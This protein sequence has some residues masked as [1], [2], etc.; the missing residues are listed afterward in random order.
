M[1]LIYTFTGGSMRKGTLFGVASALLSCPWLLSAQEP[2]DAGTS[3]A[4][5]PGSGSAYSS[6]SPLESEQLS[7]PSVS[8][9]FYEIAYELAKPKEVRGPELEQA[10]TFL[11]AAMKLDKNAKGIRPLLIEFA[12]RERTPDRSGLVYEMLVEYVDEFA[13]LEV[14]RKAVGY[15][16]DRAN[17]REER[18]RLL[19]RMLGTLGNK[20]NILGSELATLLGVLKAEKADSEA[21]AHY[22]MQAYRSHRYNAVAFAKLAEVAPEQISPAVYLERLRLALRENPSDID[23]AV[24]FAEY[25]E[26]LQ[27]YETAA[28]AYEYCADLF[29][30]LY[31]SEALPARIY[32]P[33]AISSYNTR[34]DQSQCAQ[35]AERI[36]A[37]GEFDLRLEAIAAKA[38]IKLGDNESAARTFQAAEEKA[39]KL[40][41]QQEGAAGAV[42]AGTVESANSQQVTPEQLAWFYCLAL[43]M[44]D[45]ALSWA[46]QVYAADSNSPVTAALL[47]CALVMNEQIEWAKPLIDNYDRNQIADLALAQIQLA[48]GQASLAIE[49]LISAIARDPGSFAA[50]RSKE[51]LAGQ[52]REY[53][54]PVAPD[55]VLASL[56]ST[57]GQTLVPVFTRP[58]Q[59]L[60]AQ[61]DIRGNTIPYGGELSGMAV[62][63]NSSSE[64]LVISDDGLFKGNIR[65]DADISG[66][67]TKHI[68]NLV[69]TKIQA[70][71][72]VEPGRSI[73]I[74]LRLM[75]G[76]LRQTLLTYPQASL[77]IEC[78]LY[79]DPVLTS[80]GTV[81]NRL[82]Q[83]RP[84]KVRVDRPGVELTTK[85]LRDQFN[86]ISTDRIDQKIK[87]AQ[88]FT[89]L[90]AEQ[91]AMANRKPLYRFMYAD[92][93]APL[94][95]S[96]LVHESGLLRHPGQTEW[97]VK[98]HTMAEMLPLSLD[99]ELTSAAADNL[100]HPKWPV[101]MMA[102]YLLANQQ[103][104]GFGKV[105]D[106]AK[107][108]PSQSVCDMATALSRASSELQGRL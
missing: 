36:R 106:W 8:R 75:T 100:H 91:Q 35:I 43:P 73:L 64:P 20:N 9:K 83:V 59:V 99:H 66:D 14:A 76:E 4:A 67:I 30:Y 18:E 33:W 74:P 16:L 26:R 17:S 80:D 90:L 88:L 69:F 104:R 96:A 58:E 32:L 45:K 19:E 38:A 86:S 107:K 65:V 10:I 13:D 34:Q 102:V 3:V 89:G 7:A 11:T 40:L 6:R 24:A 42:D 2:R 29:D 61:L 49:T 57:F 22:L 105:L 51:I 81:A 47:A 70:A 79:L 21:A 37:Q 60:S 93:M 82:T 25:A 103:Q 85:Y 15:L 50:E 95:R 44:P 53:V 55:A 56:Q 72:L 41:K 101:R 5:S 98:V 1:L 46:H 97:V 84:G 54:P 78:T 12:V 68:A 87:T 94:L 23:T 77:S 62:I 108:D 71:F 63:K 48:E 39:Q 28:A 31:P 27:L 92:W 52:G